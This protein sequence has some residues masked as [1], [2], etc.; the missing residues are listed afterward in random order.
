[1]WDRRDAYRVYVEKPER[2]GTLGSARHKW[3]TKT[4]K[5]ILK[6]WVNDGV[7]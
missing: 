5:Y 3:Q 2:K 6:K 1:M 4:K 7:D